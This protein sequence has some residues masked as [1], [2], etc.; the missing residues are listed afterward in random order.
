MAREKFKENV[1]NIRRKQTSSRRGLYSSVA[2]QPVPSIA[3]NPPQL[4]GTGMVM[5]NAM[6]GAAGSIMGGMESNP[7]TPGGDSL[8]FGDTYG[9][10]G[11]FASDIGI[12]DSFID[13]GGAGA[14]SSFDMGVNSFPSFLEGSFTDYP[15]YDIPF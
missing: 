4:R 3:P 1:E 11:N 13:F 14:F 15:I 7:G 9:N 2:F 6:L 8:S 5:M 12:S 10:V